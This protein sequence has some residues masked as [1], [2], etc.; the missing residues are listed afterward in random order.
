MRSALATRSILMLPTTT[1]GLRFNIRAPAQISPRLEN[2]GQCNQRQAEQKQ[3]KHPQEIGLRASRSGRKFAPD[4][5]TPAGGNH[6]R[7]LTNGIGDRGSYNVRARRN[8]VE[9]STCAPDCASD[10]S[11]EM[12]AKGCGGK[13]THRDRRLCVQGSAHKQVVERDR[14]ETDVHDKTE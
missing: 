3:H 13:S 5:D 4:K 12:P 2:G 10:D 8:K 1:I 9:D 14:A 11:P 7:A 6:G